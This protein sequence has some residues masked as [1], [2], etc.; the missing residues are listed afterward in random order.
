M[1]LVA[2]LLSYHYAIAFLFS[3]ATDCC[4]VSPLSFICMLIDQSNYP[5]LSFD[6]LRRSDPASVTFIAAAI[7]CSFF[8]CPF[9]RPPCIL[10]SVVMMYM[11]WR[12]ELCEYTHLILWINQ[13][14]SW[15][16]ISILV[17]C[18]YSTIPVERLRT[19][20]FSSTFVSTCLFQQ[21][22][23]SSRFTF[24]TYLATNIFSVFIIC[25]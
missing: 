24:S 25:I 12:Y 11:I 23:S 4:H 3:S 22:F 15:T 21:S 18:Y 1:I 19:S 7:Y 9:L 14:W 13:L 16:T 5:T 2:L 8:S 10:G 6:F 17:C 20:G